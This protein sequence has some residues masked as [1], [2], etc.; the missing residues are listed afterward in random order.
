M[1]SLSVLAIAVLCFMSVGC[2]TTSKTTGDNS[3]GYLLIAHGSIHNHGDSHSHHSHEDV[4]KR[5]WEKSVLDTVKHAKKET[6]AH[7]EVAFGMWDAHSFQMA[8]NKLTAQGVK[9]VHVIPLFV[10]S[11][12]LVIRAQKYQ[13]GI[14]PKPPE[15]FEELKRV[16]LPEGVDLVYGNPLDDSPRLSHIL[17][18]RAKSLSS[19]PAQ[20]TLILVAHGPV[21]DDDNK[22]WVKTLQ[23]HSVEIQNAMANQGRRFAKVEVLTLRDDAGKE[24]QQKA[25]KE[26]R[27]LVEQA[28]KENKTPLILPVLIAKGGIEKRLLNRLD[29][30]TF[31][32]KG[33]MIAPDKELARW[34]I[35]HMKASF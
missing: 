21:E 26:F 17:S 14:S 5:P 1:R 2:Q 24:V 6:G 8:V 22:E 15:G 13:F 18:R 30:L 4:T 10:S 23:A 9:R 16:Q 35:D 11:H 25:T 19:N 28:I 31:A 32:Y 20:E 3:V 33:E 27:G 34:I 7:I 12:S 29:G